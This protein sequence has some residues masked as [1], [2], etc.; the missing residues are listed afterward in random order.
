MN[1]PIIYSA[2]SRAAA[3]SS[4]PPELLA[5]AVELV[6]GKCRQ[7]VVVVKEEITATLNLSQKMGRS[8]VVLCERCFDASSSPDDDLLIVEFCNPEI[9]SLLTKSQAERN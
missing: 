1:E 9:K 4:V 5:C 2:L 3:V 7:Q 6:C 8:V